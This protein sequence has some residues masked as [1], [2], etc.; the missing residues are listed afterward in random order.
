MEF[1]FV[2]SNDFIY[3]VSLKATERWRVV[4]KIQVT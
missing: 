3:I 1:V 4:Q 2:L